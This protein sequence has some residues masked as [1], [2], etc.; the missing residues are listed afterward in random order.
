MNYKQSV[1][2]GITNILRDKCDDVKY[3]KYVLEKCGNTIGNAINLLI[4]IFWLMYMFVVILLIQFI[5]APIRMLVCKGRLKDKVK[6][7]L[8]T[9]KQVSIGMNSGWRR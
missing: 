2:L 1:I 8:D 9:W 5:E 3:E 6:Y 4:S 7:W